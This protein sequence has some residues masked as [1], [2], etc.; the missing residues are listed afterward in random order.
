MTD[1]EGHFGGGEVGGGDDEV[2]FIFARE[3]V[4]DDD[5][6]A[7]FWGLRVSRMLGIGIERVIDVL[8]AWIVSSMESNSWAMEAGML[9]CFCF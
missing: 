8:K 6:F 4:E 7:V 1:H 5:E 2:A 9:D 3:V